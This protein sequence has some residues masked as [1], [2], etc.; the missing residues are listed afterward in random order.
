MHLLVY[1]STP[2]QSRA[3]GTTNVQ[4][5]PQFLYVYWETSSM[6][7]QGHAPWRCKSVSQSQ[8]TKANFRHGIW[9]QPH[10]YE[11]CNM[12]LKE[13]SMVEKSV[14]DLLVDLEE[15]LKTPWGRRGPYLWSAFNTRN[16]N[17]FFGEVVLRQDNGLGFSRA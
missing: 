9:H 16:D 1:D 8:N 2:R 17:S 10:F 15:K 14:K 6:C 11:I 13:A 12:S 3:V 4:R 7:H 5:I